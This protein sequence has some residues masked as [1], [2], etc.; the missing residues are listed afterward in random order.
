MKKFLALFTFFLLFGYGQPGFAEDKQL[1]T[2]MISFDFNR[3]TPDY[4]NNQFAVWMEDMNGNLIKTIFVTQFTAEGGWDY[5]DDALPTWTKKSRISTLKKKEVD[6]ISGATPKAQRLVYKWRGEDAE[7]R[8]LPAGKYRY[9]IEANYYWDAVV[10]HSGTIKI[11]D[12]RDKHRA[13]AND[14]AKKYDIIENVSAEFI[15]LK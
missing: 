5:R 9:V 13:D 14:S 12:K 10:V 7:N 6:A 8:F 4:A 15:P 3:V 1:G 11:G 2:V